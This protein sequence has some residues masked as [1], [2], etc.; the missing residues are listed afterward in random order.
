MAFKVTQSQPDTSS[1]FR[2]ENDRFF[3]CR[4]QVKVEF[5]SFWSFFHNEYN[6]YYP[7]ESFTIVPKVRNYII[8]LENFYFFVVLF[9]LEKKNFFQSKGS[10]G[11]IHAEGKMKP[12]KPAPQ[13]SSS[14]SGLF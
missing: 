7:R 3:M 6:L 13:P 2:R 10:R 1:G 14:S 5:F 12:P 8:S 4:W 11:I 9:E